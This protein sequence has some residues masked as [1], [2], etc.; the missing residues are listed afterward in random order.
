[1][2]HQPLFFAAI[3]KAPF[4]GTLGHESFLIVTAASNIGMVDIH[5]QRPL[6]LK[7]SAV[8]QWLML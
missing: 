7:A 1:M 2:S 8:R 4:G 5:N 3:V 6:V